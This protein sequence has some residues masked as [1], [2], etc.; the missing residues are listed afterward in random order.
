M[1]SMKYRTFC[2][3]TCEGEVMLI[4]G[5]AKHPHLKSTHVPQ[6]H[7]T[8]PLVVPF[9]VSIR[10]P[11]PKETDRFADFIFITISSEASTHCITQTNTEGIPTREP[12]SGL[13]PSGSLDGTRRWGRCWR[14]GGSSGLRAWR[15]L[16]SQHCETT[17]SGR[18]TTDYWCIYS[19]NKLTAMLTW[20]WMKMT[21]LGYELGISGINSLLYLS[22]SRD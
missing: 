9:D 13:T 20:S 11:L 10:A 22:S 7:V 8:N 18:G 2:S 17:G 19:S 15:F 21:G 6:H 5:L 3:E 14:R 4:R 16:W 1:Y 12:A